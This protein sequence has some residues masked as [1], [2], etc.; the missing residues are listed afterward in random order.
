MDFV[1]NLRWGV[2]FTFVCS[3]IEVWPYG[4]SV[5]LY[6]CRWDSLTRST[7]NH[8]WNEPVDL[9]P[10]RESSRSSEQFGAWFYLSFP[11]FFPSHR[12][13]VIDA[14]YRVNFIF[15][16]I[17]LYD[18]II[19]AV[20]KSNCQKQVSYEIGY[21]ASV[22]LHSGLVLGSVGV[23]FACWF[24]FSWEVR[25]A[26]LRQPMQ[27]FLTRKIEEWAFIAGP[28]TGKV[29]ISLSLSDLISYPTF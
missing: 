21:R 24:G 1:V 14:A 16:V 4:P 17:A 26:S 13:H 5:L 8:S 29:C 25:E 7:N 15:Q 11:L 19:T 2:F 27:I 22:L 9:E 23:C 6:W 12:T 20:W 18:F 10:F 28:T 3:V